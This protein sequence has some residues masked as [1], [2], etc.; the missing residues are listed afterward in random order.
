MHLAPSTSLRLQQNQSAQLTPPIPIPSLYSP[1]PVLCSQIELVKTGQNHAYL[2]CQLFNI[3]SGSWSDTT[4]E[5]K[6]VTDRMQSDN[7]G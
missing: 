5:G 3:H 1:G 2:S 4:F 6:R 7:H